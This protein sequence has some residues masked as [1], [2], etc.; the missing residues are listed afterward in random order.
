MFPL[1]SSSHFGDVDKVWMLGCD[2][3]LEGALGFNKKK[4]KLKGAVL[5]HCEPPPPML[6]CTTPIDLPLDMLTRTGGCTPLDTLGLVPVIMSLVHRVF[7]SSCLYFKP[8]YTDEGLAN[9]QAGPCNCCCGCTKC[10]PMPSEEEPIC[11]QERDLLI[12][13]LD[14]VE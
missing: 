5:S 9:L 1:S 6:N 12:P 10:T 4:D 8:E 11:C 7:C 14:K 13:I 2:S 3:V